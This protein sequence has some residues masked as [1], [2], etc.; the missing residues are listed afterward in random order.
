[1]LRSRRAVSLIERYER[2]VARGYSVAAGGRKGFKNNDSQV[3]GLVPLGS[4]YCGRCLHASLVYA[5]EYTPTRVRFAYCVY[6]NVWCIC[7]IR[8]VHCTYSILTVRCTQPTQCPQYVYYPQNL[9]CGPTYTTPHA[10]CM[11]TVVSHLLPQTW[12]A[13]CAETK[14]G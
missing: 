13:T 5:H 14:L 6:V 10:T 4:S 11:S 9:S 3:Q 2:T 12:T 7:D 8:T 1:M